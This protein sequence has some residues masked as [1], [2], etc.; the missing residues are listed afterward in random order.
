[1]KTNIYAAFAYALYIYIYTS[2]NSQYTEVIN[3]FLLKLMP[4]QTTMINGNTMTEYNLLKILTR[5]VS[6]T[7]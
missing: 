5:F 7:I 6:K 4:G 1:M 2:L 3:E